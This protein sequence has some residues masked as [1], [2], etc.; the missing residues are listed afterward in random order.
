MNYGS[1]SV[2]SN[3]PSRK[4]ILGYAASF[5]V[6]HTWF[7][8]YYIVSTCS[9]IF[10]GHQI[11]TR[12]QAFKLLARY[13]KPSTS[14]P[15]TGNQVLLAWSMMSIQGTRRLYES[16]ALTKPSKSKMWVG[17]W[18]I[19]IAF[20]VAMGIT[21]WIEGITT[22]DVD[23][24]MASL[25]EFSRPSLRT[26][27]AVPLFLLAS[28]VQHE[29]H[30][31]LASLKKYTLPDNPYFQSVVCP[32]YTSEILVYVAFAIAAAPKGQVANRTVL[33]GLGFVVSNLGVTA[34]STRKWYV[35]KFGEEKVKRRWRMVPVLLDLSNSVQVVRIEVAGC[36][37]KTSWLLQN[38]PS[39]LALMSSS[40]LAQDDVQDT[41]T[42]RL[43]AMEGQDNAGAV[44]PRLGPSSTGL[45]AEAD[46]VKSTR[47]STPNG[48]RSSPPPAMARDGGMDMDPF[49][50]SPED[51]GVKSDS[52]AET[53]VLPG[54]DG[55]S[56]S[57]TRKSIK[58]EDESEDEEG[59]ISS[60]PHVDAGGRDLGE[61]ANR[62]DPNPNGSETVIATALGKRKRVKHSQNKDEPAHLG[63]SSG[64][65]SVP[66]SPIATTRSSLSKPAASDSDISRSPSPRSPHSTLRGKAKS[67]DRVLPR[68]KQNASGDEGETR[69]SARQRSSGADQK[70]SREKD[71][72]GPSKPTFDSHSRKRTRS[73]SPP[74]RSHRRS[75][76]SQL[77][78]KSIH[79]LSHKKKRVPAPLQSTEYQS[80][81]SSASGSSSHARSSRLHNLAAPVTGES[82][83]SPAKMPPHKKHVN[84]SGQTWLARACAAGKLDVAKQRLAERP[85]DLNVGDNAQNTPLHTA[86]IDGYEDIVKLLLES[87]CL[88]DPVNVARDTPLHDAIENG[89][90]DVVKLLLDAGAN[91]RKANGQGEDP[92]DLVNDNDGDKA[93]EEM[94]DAIIAAKERSSDVRRSSEDEQM[95][96]LDNHLSHPKGSPRQ[97]PPAHD[98]QSNIS[99]R[100]AGTRSIKT[101]DRILYQ[102][103]DTEELRKAAAENDM[104]A[105]VR[106]LEVHSS[107]LD[108]PRSLI[109]AAKAGHHEAISYML[110]L[111]S[112]NPDPQPLKD[113]PADSATPILAAIGRDNL[114]VIELLLNQ[115]NFDPTRLIKGETYYEIAKKRGGHFW[116]EEEAMLRKAFDKYK[117]EHQSLPRKPRS[118]GLRRDGRDADRDARRA[119]RREEQQTPQSH[120]RTTSIPKIKEVEASKIQ[121]RSP[122][123]SSQSKESQMNAKRGPGRPRKEES[124]ASEAL[125]DR[126]TTPLGPPKQRS[127]PKRSESDIG[128]ASESETATKP[129]RKLVSGREFRGERE[130]DK[131]RRASVASNA[132]SASIKDRR[133]GDTKTDK[134]ARTGSAN[135]PRPSKSSLNDQ[136]PTSDKSYADKDKQ[137]STKRDDSK[138]RLSAIRGEIPVKRPRKSETPPRSVKQEVNG[139]DSG[140]VPQKRRRLEGEPKTG[141]K[142]ETA[143]SSSPDQRTTTA[144]SSHENGSVKHSSDLKERAFSTHKRVDSPDNPRHA[145]EETSVKPSEKDPKAK[146]KGESVDQDVTMEDTEAAALQVEEEQ[147]AQK[148]R[149]VEEQEAKERAEKAAREKKLEEE[150]AEEAAKQARLIKEQTEREEE[151][152]RKQDAERKERQ[153][154]EDA[155]AHAREVER[156]RILYQEQE[157]LK[158]EEQERRRA[159]ALEQQRAE[160]LRLEKEKMEERLSKLPLLLRWFEQDND[161]RRTEKA[162]LFRFVEGFRYDTIRPEATG[163]P[164]GREE[165]MLNT[166]AALLL[167]E[168]DL[169]LSRYTAWEHIPLSQAAK[170]AVWQF[171]NPIYALSHPSLLSLRRKFPDNGGSSYKIIEKCKALFMELD[172]FFIK[173]S[174]F[175]Y[176]VPNFPHLRGLEL[177][178]KY[179]ELQESPVWPP[180]PGKWKQDPDA[181]PNQIFAPRPKYYI[182]GVFTKQGQFQS[183]K[184]STTSFGERR[185][186]RRGLIQVFPGELDYERLAREQGLLHLISDCSA[187]HG[188]LN[189]TT[190]GH[191]NGITSPS[192]DKSKS[193]NGGSPHLE[194]ETILPLPLPN[195]IHDAEMSN[196]S[197]YSP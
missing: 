20:Y 44:T 145:S 67:V 40:K 133:E 197:S 181:D 117:A 152:K 51:A 196:T 54:K 114:Q 73:I 86:S 173:V 109:N 135:V 192:S 175:M 112:F 49:N 94:R 63:N 97:T 42:P 124:V 34:D 153:R 30:K 36:D 188:Q 38:L 9:S 68:R 125:S 69:S 66:T 27:I 178:V 50:A 46:T 1:R 119:P 167:G 53:I 74:T 2:E 16:L 77:P 72:R 164:N 65:S 111:G 108:D 84:S 56:P 15:M 79:G 128:V 13:S 25:L 170:Q 176:V 146:S 37:K 107:H 187:S 41:A 100:N 3:D 61:A 106:I 141:R 143:S 60:A 161:P 156:Q 131:Q 18:A 98:A 103:L 183:S 155:E 138:D 118:P 134:L 159:Q 55:H 140:E 185:V 58:H 194:N 132:S 158:R 149:E 23:Q 8:H 19:G 121:H 11:L 93:A 91:P 59:E 28:G 190:N 150:R 177:V 22:L 168:K 48:I 110:A 83:T 139:Y 113:I 17:L 85:E 116:K 147:E 182:N 120:R 179:R 165:W 90:V 195:G 10:W 75:I 191:V 45:I 163:Q 71:H 33:A 189:G 64:L 127:H 123:S 43:D 115:S 76:S 169:Q 184:I 5:Q 101:S 102:R 12:G 160:R 105:I 95:Q 47:A 87:G 166:H 104:G 172:L 186:P 92:Y 154:Q 96:E 29:C 39:R 144:K 4:N 21:V 7:T 162:T 6:P 26:A 148:R 137:R 88:V 32:H 14:G 151:A 89:H 70:H 35:E 193:T 78:S 80:D 136:E 57:K 130:L 171:E 31:H 157:R 24:P 180:A 82:T 62:V 129:R 174:E 99:R 81:E 126:E 142:A 52:E 122:Q